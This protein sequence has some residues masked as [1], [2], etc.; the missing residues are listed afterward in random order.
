MAE[1]VEMHSK[2]SIEG[3]IE[4]N[5][6]RL[7]EKLESFIID[8]KVITE[9]YMRVSGVKYQSCTKFKES[10]EFGKIAAEDG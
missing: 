4:F 8:G 10:L 3:G 6:M 9:L 1:I 5:V 7:D 2:G